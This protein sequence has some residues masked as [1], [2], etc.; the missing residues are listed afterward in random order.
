VTFI[1][2]FRTVTVEDGEW[3]RNLIRSADTR[4]SDYTFGNILC[5]QKPYNIRVA[6]LQPGLIIEFDVDGLKV[7]SYPLGVEDESKLREVIAQIPIVG[8]VSSEQAAVIERLFPGQCKTEEFPDLFDYIYDIDRLAE[9]S[10]KKLHAKRNYINRFTAQYPNYVVE[11]LT[12]ANINECM[13][14]DGIWISG[15]DDDALTDEIPGE[16]TALEETLTNF[17]SLDMLGAVLRQEPGGGIIAFTLGELL[18]RDTF[19]THFEKAI[20]AIDGAYQMINREF[21]RI[22]KETYPFVK[23]IN[24][25]EDLGLPN[26]R[27]SKHSYYPD[28]MQEKLRVYLNHS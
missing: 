11:R 20:A 19:N 6:D 15:K 7:Y 26:L 9:L 10:G 18:G 8:G 21:A 14:L 4:N 17:C 5:W 23:Y 27:K 24:R 22:V 2:P 3:I 28:L 12:R 1:L 16:I 13:M 25:E